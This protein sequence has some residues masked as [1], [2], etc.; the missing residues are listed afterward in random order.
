M[1]HHLLQSIGRGIQLHPY[2]TYLLGFLAPIAGAYW[3]FSV[4]PYTR[5]RTERLL[6]PWHVRRPAVPGVLEHYAAWEWASESHLTP[7]GRWLFQE[8]AQS[9]ETLSD[10]LRRAHLEMGAAA[11]ALYADVV[12]EADPAL[13][14]RIAT[15]LGADENQIDRLLQAQLG[16]NREMN[17]LP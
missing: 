14:R 2:L 4:V 9:N 17:R 16:T 12:T 1:A 7:F 3:L 8:L 15:L 13:I 5:P 10:L 11:P 6:S